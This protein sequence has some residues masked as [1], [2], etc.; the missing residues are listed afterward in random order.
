[1][2]E[3]SN[4]WLLVILVVAYTPIPVLAHAL[5]LQV[6]ANEGKLLVEVY[7]DDN[8]PA[9]AA[10]VQLLDINGDVLAES[11][12]D[13]MGRIAFSAPARG[14]YQV[15]ADA[16]DGHLATTRLEILEGVEAVS[17]APT[18]EEFTEFPWLK[19][20]LVVAV[21]LLVPLGYLFRKRAGPH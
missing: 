17:D 20:S 8:Q 21:L 10:R 18:R 6:R 4:R 2:G 19:I 16:G 15:R 14:R 13:S 5:G 1:V 12:T 3:R 11:E 9:K 7:F